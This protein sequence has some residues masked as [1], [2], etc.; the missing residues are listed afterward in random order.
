MNEV[1]R[2]MSFLKRPLGRI[3]FVLGVAA[4]NSALLIAALASFALLPSGA[5]HMAVLVIMAALM[6]WWF[7]LHAR[8]FA[9]AGGSIGW[10]AAT[11]ATA[12]ATFAVS[13]LI[14]AALWSVPAVQ[15]EAFRTGGSDYRGHVET[16]GAVAEF[17]RWLGGW[18]NAAWALTITGILA[19]VM[20][21]VALATLAVSTVALMLPTASAAPSSTITSL[22][23]LR[24]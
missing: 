7:S 8:R 19:V 3:P 14:I 24:R 13:Y 5:G 6:W 16:W 22:P 15:E 23:P 20:G 2:A 9:G 12:F 11:A 4:A 21:V 1:S 10:P 17:G 18:V